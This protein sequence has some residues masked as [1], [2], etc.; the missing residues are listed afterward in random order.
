MLLIAA[1][2]AESIANVD[3]SAGL[4]SLLSPLGRQQA[5][6][7][8]ERIRSQRLSAIYCSPFARCIETAAP[9]AEAL[10]MPIRIRPDLAEF[11]HL[12]PGTVTDAG[13]PLPEELL[14]SDSRL[15]RCPDWPGE[16]E[17]TPIDE[18]HENLILRIRRLAGYLKTRWQAPGD[19]VLVISHGSPI[20][21]LI[22]AWLS[23]SP[24]PSFRF[25]IDNAGLSALRFH[26]E[27]SSLICLNECSHLVGLPVA[28]ASNFAP[29]G[30]P[31]AIPP[32][33]YW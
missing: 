27:I 7:L 21:R 25:I 8:C 20:A 24:G 10:D 31:K 2:H 13:L 18:S 30:I 33:D 11:H 14:A 4:N 32:S 9:I 1:R 15:I 5:T 17:W 16:L 12:Q 3:R 28:A 22:D 26:Q 19:V 6:A 29:G 23:P